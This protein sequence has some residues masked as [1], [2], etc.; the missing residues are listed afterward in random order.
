M[1]TESTPQG[2]VNL[3]QGEN[4]ERY[5]SAFTAMAEGVV[6]QDS[7]GRITFCNPSAERILGLPAGKA[8]GMTFADSH[9]RAIRED[10]SP[11]PGTEHPAMVTLR[12]GQSCT[13]VIMGLQG[14]GE[15][16]TWIS[17]NSEPLTRGSQTAPGAVVSTFAD[18]TRQ[19]QAEM[20]LKARENLFRTL[21]ENQNEGIGI[22]DLE[23]RFLITNPAGDEIFGVASGGLA[24]RCLQDFLTPEG[25]P[26][27]RQET[28][29][30]SAGKR[31]QYELEIIRE[32]DKS[33]RTILVSAAPQFDEAGRVSGTFGV[34]SDITERKRAEEA[35]REK[36]EELDRYFTLNLDLLWI[37]D[38][39][40]RFRRLNPEWEKVLGYPLADLEGK[41]FLDFVHPDDLQATLAAFSQL[42]RQEKLPSFTNRYRR[43][44]GS[45][46]WIDWRAYPQGDLI[47]AVGRDVTDRILVE[48]ALQENEIRLRLTFDQAPVGAA[49]IGLDRRFLQVNDAL[50]R[51]LGYQTQELIGK[52][53]LEIT[54][55]EHTPADDENAQL[56]AEGKID[57]YTT[58]KRYIRRDGK[59]VWVHLTA[60]VVKDSSGRALYF[61]TMVEDITERKSA[62][63]E[64]ARLQAQFL[65]A[66]KMESIGR[67]AGGVAHDFNNL[68]T[69][70]N[71]YS[72]MALD[73]MSPQDPLRN[74][75][76]EVHKAGESAAALVRQLLAFSRKQV[77]Q[78]ELVC[79]NK[80]VGAMK[81]MLLPLVGE[82][83]EI[84]TKLR[85]TLDPVLAD[86]HQMEQ[87]IM[88][89][90]INA[91]DA[92]P[93]GGR[94]IIETD[95]VSWK[96]S[97]PQCLADV[98]PGPYVRVTVSDTGTGMNEHVRQH[99]FEPFFSTK[100]VGQ[101]TGLGLATVHGIVL[102]SGGHIDVESEPGK[103]TSFHVYLPAVGVKSETKSAPAVSTPEGGAETILLVEDQAEVRQFTAALLRDYGYTV[104]ETSGGEEALAQCAAKRI[105]LLLTDVVMPKMSGS[106]L[107][108]R[109]R[110]LQ[111]LLKVLFMSGYSDE[112][113][114]SRSDSMHGAAFIQKPFAREALALKVREVLGGEKAAAA[115][116]SRT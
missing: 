102:Q 56:L 46:R 4:E 85:P 69:V 105:D 95:H 41:R 114:G 21:V 18:V 47:Y 74:T 66:Q 112:L 73:R 19:R 43:K 31:S 5:R 111:P 70:I 32:S 35:L 38:T 23:E 90:T 61:L 64:R 113:L 82:D 110:S 33:K 36:S 22:V 93:N 54:H 30:R 34:F 15:E 27:V 17:I 10:G 71:G 1:K 115:S 72:A 89:L 7:S 84:I 57:Q 92:M 80:M 103:G 12:T 37:A 42:A 2:G 49:M 108:A 101:G 40:G 104:L 116:V 20:A 14:E 76:R 88:N 87:V 107:A 77:L 6:F 28:K 60:R 52:T 79:L 53:F 25:L 94:L 68:L 67:L 78:Q 8:L 16:V 45:Y 83:I 11:L 62:E 44:D 106:D 24:G 109:V 100:E 39:D 63:A 96:S 86:R 65:Q 29:A 91:R 26:F 98:R 55:P 13:G 99:L 58:D 48:K 50:C 59:V 97:R 51:L 81:T 3:A 75:I 9:W